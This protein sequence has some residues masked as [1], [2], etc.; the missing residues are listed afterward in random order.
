MHA[1]LKGIFFNGLIKSF[2][3]S[4]GEGIFH[5]TKVFSFENGY[6]YITNITL[7]VLDIILL[8]F[9]HVQ[10]EI[11]KDFEDPVNNS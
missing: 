4:S 8:T 3:F 2:R 10:L 7:K 5:I 6:L 9:L 11:N 1:H